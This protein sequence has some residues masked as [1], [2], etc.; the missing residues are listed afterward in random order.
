M[1]GECMRV[2]T[3]VVWIRPQLR[4][5]RPVPLSEDCDSKMKEMR[6]FGP[7]VDTSGYKIYRC[8]TLYRG[9]VAV[10]T[11]R[12]I[13]RGAARTASQIPTQIK[14]FDKSGA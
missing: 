12:K 5:K 2:F 6:L 7:A 9:A 4:C 11:G 14:Q 3:Q 8:R 1:V 13:R 10:M